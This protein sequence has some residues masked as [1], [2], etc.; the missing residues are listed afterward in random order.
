M[1]QNKQPAALPQATRRA[2]SL[3]RERYDLLRG[4]SLHLVKCHRANL[5]RAFEEATNNLRE[6]FNGRRS[7]AADVQH[8]KVDPVTLL[9]EVWE[10]RREV[11]KP[12]KSYEY[13]LHCAYGVR[14]AHVCGARRGCGKAR[15]TFAKNVITA[16]LLAGGTDSS[17]L[18]C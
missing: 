14:D 8:V 18:T 2:V 11:E 5:M 12:P 1:V 4:G 3:T 17:N 6:R 7:V 16:S 13:L 9:L 15:C 10:E